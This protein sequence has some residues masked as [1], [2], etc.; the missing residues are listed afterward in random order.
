MH[1]RASNIALSGMSTRPSIKVDRRL[2]EKIRSQL[3][4]TT[5]P[6]ANEDI[7]LRVKGSVRREQLCNLLA[8]Y[9]LVKY[10]TEEKTEGEGGG[11]LT[12]T[13]LATPESALSACKGEDGQIVKM[14]VE[15]PELFSCSCLTRPVK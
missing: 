10:V 14:L 3:P 2:R 8:P 12:V 7:E 4:P 5:A 1:N 11:E 13:I 6:T 9:G 15:W